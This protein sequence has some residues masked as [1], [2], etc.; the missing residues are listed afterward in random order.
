MLLLLL[1]GNAAIELIFKKLRWRIL[2]AAYP[3]MIFGYDAET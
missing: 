3:Q 2:L 1:Q